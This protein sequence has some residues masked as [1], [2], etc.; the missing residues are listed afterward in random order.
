MSTLSALA[1]TWDH[2][3]AALCDRH[4]VW[5]T[6]HGRCRLLCPHALGW[7]AGRPMLLGYQT[8]GQTSTGALDADPRRR[9]RCMFV[10]EIDLVVAA[11]PA[12]H[13]GTADNYNHARPFSAIDHVAIAITP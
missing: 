4:P 13:W 7:K 12:S 11:E 1:A 8:G 10:D 5:V 9:W 2:L 3:A 6:Y